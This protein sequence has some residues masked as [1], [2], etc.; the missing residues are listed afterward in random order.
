M[1][2]TLP[3][4]TFAMKELGVDY[5]VIVSK[6]TLPRDDVLVDENVEATPVGGGADGFGSGFGGRPVPGAKTPPVGKTD[7]NG[8]KPDGVA[9]PEKQREFHVKRFDFVLQ[10]SWKPTTLSERLLKRKQA[11][12]AAKAAKEQSELAANPMQ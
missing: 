3:H 12:D 11:E 6:N 9:V 4:G 5:P 8:K 1:E 2:V 7:P 10:F